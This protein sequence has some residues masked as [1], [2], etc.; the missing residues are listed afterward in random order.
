MPLIPFN[1]TLIQSEAMMRL[2]LFVL[3]ASAA[4]AALDLGIDV[5]RWQGDIDWDQ[6][7]TN[8]PAIEF[9]LVKGSEGADYVDPKFEFNFKSA[10]ARGF[11]TGF[12]HFFRTKSD[13]GVP[14]SVDEQVANIGRRMKSVNFD[15]DTDFFVLDV[16]ERPADPGLMPGPGMLPNSEFSRR[17]KS[18]MDQV[19]QK[20]D[21]RGMIYGSSYYWNT[22]VHTPSIDMSRYGLWAARYPK[23][24]IGKPLSQC[25]RELGRYAPDPFDGFRS[26]QAWQFTNKGTVNGITGPVD[27]DVRFPY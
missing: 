12:Y 14:V 13:T 24:L 8:K 27:V 7:T 21:T 18:L 19:E 26:V 6:V 2:A 9:V 10:K 5:S 20:Y 11:H 17:I 16:E 22:Y 1:G 15:P 25:L 23:E 4:V 3:M